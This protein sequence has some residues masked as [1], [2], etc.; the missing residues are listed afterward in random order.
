[1]GLMVDGR[2]RGGGAQNVVM[3]CLVQT[4]RPIESD[5]KNYIRRIPSGAVGCSKRPS[6]RRILPVLKLRADLADEKV[7]YF[8]CTP[9]GYIFGFV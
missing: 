3:T 1:M 8:R 9:P 7:I 4:L 2:K 6:R 5:G